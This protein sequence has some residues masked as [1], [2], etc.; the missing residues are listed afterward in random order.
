[1]G[2]GC[3]SDNGVLDLLKIDEIMDAEKYIWI[4]IHDAISSEKHLISNGFIYQ[5]HKHT[6]Q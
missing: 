2:S 5:P 3:I 4:L 6:M 1:M